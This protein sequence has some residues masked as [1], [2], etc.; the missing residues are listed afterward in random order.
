MQYQE[1]NLAAIAF[2][3]AQ[4]G[5]LIFS[6][7]SD[8][9]FEWPKEVAHTFDV[10]E[11]SVPRKSVGRDLAVFPGIGEII[12]RGDERHLRAVAHPVL[13]KI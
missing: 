13:V 2:E 10:N 11:G 9:V 1:E 5:L 6:Q 7:P 8:W 3:I 12:E 4:F